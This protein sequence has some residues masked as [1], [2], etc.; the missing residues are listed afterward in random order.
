MTTWMR[1][2]VLPLFRFFCALALPT[3]VAFMMRQENRDALNGNCKGEM[4]QLPITRIFLTQPSVSQCDGANKTCQ[5]PELQ[6][7]QQ[8][9]IPDRAQVPGHALFGVLIGKDLIESYEVYKRPQE[10]TESENVLVVL[11]KFGTRLDGHSG[12]VHGGILS[13]I[14][15]DALGFGY[16]AL[17]VHMAVTANLKVDF[18]A[19][20]P[21]GA[22]VRVD[23]QLEYREGRKLF[24]KAQMTSLDKS[25]LY[26]EATSL[27]IVPRN[28]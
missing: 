5:L 28:A 12:V 21:A 11:V 13:L 9:E 18:R 19:P 25:I 17:G 2:P 14:F 8:M 7:Y 27:Y 4:I 24:W 10:D 26:A 16:E 6:S 20:V 22:K 1:L 23:A 3:T 15:D